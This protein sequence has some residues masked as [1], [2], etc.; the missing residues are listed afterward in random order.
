MVTQVWVPWKCVVV[1]ESRPGHSQCRR[2]WSAVVLRARLLM[3]WETVPLVARHHA[4][5]TVK[6][7]GQILLS[8]VAPVVVDSNSECSSLPKKQSMAGSSAPTSLGTSSTKL[9]MK[10]CHVQSIAKATGPSGIS[11]RTVVAQMALNLGIGSSQWRLSMGACS[12]A[13]WTGLR[14]AP[15]TQSQ[16]L[17]QLMQSVSGQNMGNVVPH[18]STRSRRLPSPRLASG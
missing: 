11:A 12:A 16:C 14:S 18:A 6:V 13:I 10:M 17:A 8:A 9:A 3:A 4:Q 2:N 5:L 1:E 7:T 15:A